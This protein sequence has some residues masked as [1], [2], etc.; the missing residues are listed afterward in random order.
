[1]QLLYFAEL[2]AKSITDLSNNKFYLL[3]YYLM[4]SIHLCV[5][6]IEL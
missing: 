5:Y 4:M 3:G 2:D 1:M 6:P